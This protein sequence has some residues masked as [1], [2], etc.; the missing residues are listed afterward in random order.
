MEEIDDDMEYSVIDDGLD[1]EAQ[2]VIADYDDYP[3]YD[4]DGEYEEGLTGPGGPDYGQYY[5]YDY[6]SRN[7]NSV[8]DALNE[9]SGNNNVEENN[10]VGIDDDT[11]VEKEQGNPIEK[12]GIGA[13][14]AV[15]A[16][17]PA[18]EVRDAA[19]PCRVLT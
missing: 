17:I 14:S 6:D 5:D 3:Q 11:N 8:G 4:Y 10:S 1:N 18:V 9:G 12:V 16:A 15:M 13:Q 2:N 7:Q 19:A